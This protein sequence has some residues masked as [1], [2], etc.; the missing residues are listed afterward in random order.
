MTT[1]PGTVGAQYQPK[2]RAAQDA[3]NER[4]LSLLDANE[5]RPTSYVQRE[6]A[7]IEGRSEPF[8]HDTIVKALTLLECEGRVSSS[9]VG[10]EKVWRLT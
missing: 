2:A 4:I 3:R 1:R 9:R 7:R 8:H 10:R 6:L 5:D